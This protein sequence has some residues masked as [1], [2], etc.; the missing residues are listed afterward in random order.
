MRM[1]ICQTVS[2]ILDSYFFD[3]KVRKKLIEIKSDDDKK[4]TVANIFM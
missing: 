3:F 1:A 2:T 4:I